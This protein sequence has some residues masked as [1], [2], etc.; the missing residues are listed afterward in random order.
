METKR[1]VG[2]RPIRIAVLDTGCSID[3]PFFDFVGQRRRI[4]GW[5]DWVEHSTSPT[6]CHGHGTHL[7]TLL[8]QVAPHAE[9]FI[10]RVAGSSQTLYKS[11]ANVS[12][13][14]R[15]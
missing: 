9:I 11:D 10:A 7:V 1:P 2:V 14:G 13:V 5:R 12:E 6:D 15:S 4:K 3:A 8:L